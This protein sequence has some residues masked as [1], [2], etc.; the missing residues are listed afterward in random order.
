MTN[1]EHPM[2]PSGWQLD[3]WELEARSSVDRALI[4][5]PAI[6]AGCFGVVHRKALCI[7]FAAGANQE[8]DACCKAIAEQVITI[9]NIGLSGPTGVLHS[10]GYSS[11]PAFAQMISHQLRATRRPKPPSLKEQALEDFDG[12]MSELD[13]AGNYSNCAER[14]RRA[15]Q[16]LPD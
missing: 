13:G 16:Q 3:R 2:R 10:E 5:E 9:D 6:R 15:L 4:N 7:A 14:I 12:L 8:L 1:N 11:W